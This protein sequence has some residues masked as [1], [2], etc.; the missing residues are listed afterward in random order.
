[1]RFPRNLLAGCAAV[2]IAALAPASA[3][4]ASSHSPTGE[5]SV[6]TECPWV[7]TKV[8]LC[9]YAEFGG[10]FSVGA[11]TVAV[12]NPIVLQGGYTEEPPTFV[13]AEN[14]ITF[15]KTPQPVLGG[16]VGIP[17][18]GSWPVPLQKAYEELVEEGFTG[19]TATIELA[20]PASAISFSMENLLLEEGT[21]LGL[22][23]KIKLSNPL[24]GSNCY[25]GSNEKPLPFD[26]TTGPSG[27]LAGTPGELTFNPEFTLTTF[28]GISLV[29]G[30]LAEPEA[31][32]CGGAFS[33]FVNPFVNSIFGLP[34][35]PEENSVNLEGVLKAAE[36]AAAK[37][38]DM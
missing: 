8:T 25:V 35:G 12:T 10:S 5:F 31:E 15:P 7:N 24:F 32:G 4:S 13:A 9:I 14:F 23:V 1:M 26:L 30:T 3:A 21:A 33:E 34:T 2:A 27:S 20:K 18:P 38:K 37:A 6:F 36:A 11:K 19:I 17:P 28:K 16:L 29:N 22:P